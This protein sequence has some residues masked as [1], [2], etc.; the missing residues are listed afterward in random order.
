MIR[1]VG[2]NK[3]KR[4]GTGGTLAGP[5]AANFFNPSV[6][7]PKTGRMTQVAFINEGAAATESQYRASVTEENQQ[8]HPVN[9]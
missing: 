9:T 2:D 8:Q 5:D 6:A 4:M 3:H 7:G 1:R